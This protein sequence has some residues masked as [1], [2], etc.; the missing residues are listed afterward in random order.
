MMFVMATLALVL[1]LVGGFAGAMYHLTGNA[2]ERWGRYELR[3]DYDDP[4]PGDQRFWTLTGAKKY[5]A[6]MKNDLNEVVYV[7]DRKIGK[8]L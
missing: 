5:L 2:L 7:Y 6:V 4:F 8:R 1:V 3:W